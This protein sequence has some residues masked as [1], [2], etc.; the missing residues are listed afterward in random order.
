MGTRI[1]SRIA[2]LITE[3]D[4]PSKTTRPAA[5]AATDAKSWAKSVVVT[6][7][8]TNDTKTPLARTVTAQ[9]R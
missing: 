2:P 1:S 9:A 7:V 5:Y 3:S 8:T 6:L 4:V